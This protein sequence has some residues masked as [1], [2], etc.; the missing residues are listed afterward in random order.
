MIER[1]SLERVSSEAPVVFVSEAYFALVVRARERSGDSSAEQDEQMVR[2]LRDSGLNRSRSH[3][4]GPA[5]HASRS[6]AFDRP[7][8]AHSCLTAA[9]H[10]API[11]AP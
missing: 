7:L 2:Q 5:F 1:T 10:R 8:S 3:L 9:S 6:E 11:P 4:E